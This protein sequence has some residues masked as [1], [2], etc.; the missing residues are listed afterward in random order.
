MKIT[1]FSCNPRFFRDFSTEFYCKIAF[2]RRILK[3]ERNRAPRYPQSRSPSQTALRDTRKA[4]LRAKPRSATPA[5]P[6]YEP[7]RAPRYPRSRSPSQTALRDTRKAAL[8]ANPCS[9]L[10]AK[11]LSF[12]RKMSKSAAKSC[13]M[14][15]FRGFPTAFYCK[16][17]NPTFIISQ[18]SQKINREADTFFSSSQFHRSSRFSRK[19]PPK[20]PR[21]PL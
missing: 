18:T 1:A 2:S 21:R 8:R 4:A 3:L 5:K 13:K 11:P 12:R 20:R 6:L 14:R 9:A 16:S 15:N 17:R 7:N 19:Q 10:P